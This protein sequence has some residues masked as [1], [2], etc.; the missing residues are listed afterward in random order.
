[1]ESNNENRPAIIPLRY[2]NNIDIFFEKDGSLKSSSKRSLAT[3][4]KQYE[5]S[6]KAYR[7]FIEKTNE[8][9]KK[10]TRTRIRN[11][12]EETYVDY[13]LWDK[14]DP[15]GYWEYAMAEFNGFNGLDNMEWEIDLKITETN[16][17]NGYT[18]EELDAM[19]HE[20]D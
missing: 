16:L 19:F 14:D 20:E 4:V 1:M 3:L 10:Y 9:K 2:Y 17:K 5:E 6:S 13:D 8:A 15:K 18:R 7:A 12:L 11:G